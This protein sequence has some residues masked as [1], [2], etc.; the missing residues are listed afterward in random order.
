[1][2]GGGN[3]RAAEQARADEQARQ[4]TIARTQGSINQVFDDPRRAA[5]ILD[6]VNAHRD[7]NM[8]SLDEQK[9]VADR[10]LRFGLASRGLLGGSAHVD[11]QAEFGRDYSKGLLEVDR[12]AR[13]LG[14]DIESADQDSRA[15][16]ISLATSG[17]DATTGAQQAA[18][19]MRSSLEAGKASAQMQGLGD[20]FGRFGKFYEDSRIAKRN[21]EAD[22]RAF[23][24]YGALGGTS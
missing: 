12:R 6:A 22:A 13:G 24:M 15:R 17:L 11:K 3:N 7:F 9:G 2:S 16:L 19:S 23:G 4:A 18:A 8:Q 5:D 10:Q 21:R 14:A 1:M 20:I